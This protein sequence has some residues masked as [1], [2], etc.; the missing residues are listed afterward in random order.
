METGMV[1]LFVQAGFILFKIR[2]LRG[3]WLIL[4][5]KCGSKKCLG[6]KLGAL[7]RRAMK[8]R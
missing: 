5:K 6:A 8:A 3:N 4:A 7:E 1:P 2:A